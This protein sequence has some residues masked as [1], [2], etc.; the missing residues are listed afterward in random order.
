MQ[1]GCRER[2]VRA[3]VVLL[4]GL[5]LAGCNTDQAA[6]GGGQSVAFDTIDGPPPAVFS[7]L[8]QGL[9]SESQARRLSVASHAET[10]NYRVRGYLAAHSDRSGKVSVSWL[11]DVYDKDKQRALRISGSEAIP[12][13]HKN[14]WD[15]LD[16][17]LVQ[18]IAA[19]SVGELASFLGT[20]GP[21]TRSAEGAQTR[22]MDGRHRQH[23][24]S[25]GR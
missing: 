8:V 11:W 4:A 19:S 24:E 12:G 23:R 17:A 20:A 16:D 5:A 13:K 25:A 14:A 9:N 22:R 18:K 21:T 6:L 10:A 7:K 2:A 1:W 3:V 15:A